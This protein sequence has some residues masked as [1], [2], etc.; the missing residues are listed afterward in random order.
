MTHGSS[1]PA[2]LTALSIIKRLEFPDFC[3]D[4]FPNL[5]VIEEILFF[6]SGHRWTFASV[7]SK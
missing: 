7:L 4:D 2:A 5:L 6:V 1:L 3:R